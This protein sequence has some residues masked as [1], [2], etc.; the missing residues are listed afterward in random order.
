MCQPWE[1]SNRMQCVSC[2]STDDDDVWN[3]HRNVLNKN[4]ISNKTK[5]FYL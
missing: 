3:E 4:Y 1:I 2:F 5:C